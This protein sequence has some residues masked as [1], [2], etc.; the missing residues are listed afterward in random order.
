MVAPLA[1]NF[2]TMHNKN[3]SRRMI[4][5]VQICRIRVAAAES[6]LKVLRN[7]AQQAKRRRKA[8]KRMAQRSRKQFKRFK[9]ELADLQQTLAKAEAKLFQAGGRAMARKLAKAKPAAKPGVRPAR[10][11]KAAARKPKRVASISLAPRKVA[12]RKLAIQKTKPVAEAPANIPV[13]DP[14]PSVVQ[15]PEPTQ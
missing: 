8:A 7:E 4:G 12:A 6:K 5:E 2:L 14:T 15:I 11:P 13:I 1:D 9:A 3:G 10:K